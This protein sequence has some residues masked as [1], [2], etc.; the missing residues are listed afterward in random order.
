MSLGQA[1]APYL[2]YLRR[3]GRA[4]SGSQQS[5][6]AL[7]AGLLETLVANPGAVDPSGD[8]RIQL[9]RMVHDNF[10]LMAGQ[11][12]AEEN[13]P[14]EVAIADA[15]LR[16]IPSLARQALLLTAVEGFNSEETGRIIGRDT[17]SVDELIAQATDEIDRQTRAR[18]LIIEDEPIIA[19]D[20]EMI[21]RDLGHDVVAVATTHAEAVAEAQ[22][23]QPGLVLADIQLADN[24]SGIEAVQEILQ[25]VKLP[26]IFITA[27]PERLLT[28]D[29]PEPAF[30]LTKP[31]QP[32]T[33]RAAIS[34][35]L[36][37]DESTVPA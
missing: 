30:L 17:A 8:L 3:Y 4:I 6:D 35:V 10:G 19:M 31:Y 5:G 37:F 36:F 28:G 13:A 22:K 24:S 27:F 25:D 11:S 33:L 32:A 14:A 23:H 34:Q 26:V 7:V 12:A 9:Y 29:R 21:V 15:R 1:I 20:I 16:R 2:P 18:I